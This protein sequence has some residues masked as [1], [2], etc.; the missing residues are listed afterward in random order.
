MELDL[1]ESICSVADSRAKTSAKQ[2]LERASLAD[3]QACF[4]KWHESFVKSRQHGLSLRMCPPC[5]LEGWSKSLKPLPPSGM[6]WLGL[7]TPL[8]VSEPHTSE[9]ECFLLPTPT[10]SMGKRGLGISWTGRARMSSDT[11][12]FMLTVFGNFPS[13]EFYEWMMG[14][15]KGWTEIESEP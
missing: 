4:L 5:D 14:F 2:G 3:A 13:V 12:R 9:R 15:P 10:A 11:E 1:E 7:V 6:A 8:Q